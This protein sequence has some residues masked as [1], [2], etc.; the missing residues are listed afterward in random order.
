MNKILNFNIGNQLF[1]IEEDAY[2]GLNNYLKTLKTYFKYDKDSNEIMQ[3]LENR[4]AEIFTESISKKKPFVTQQDVENMMVKLGRTEDFDPV[5][6]GKITDKSGSVASKALTTSRKILKKKLMR[7]PNDRIIGGVCAGLGHYF[8]ISS[9]IIRLILLA[10]FLGAGVGFFLYIILWMIMPLAK[11]PSDFML[12]RGLP[13]DDS[14]VIGN[15][16]AKA[17]PL[18]PTY[19]N[20]ETGEKKLL[21][22]PNEKVI[23]GVSSGLAEYFYIDKVLVRLLFIGLTIFNGV[24]VLL[25][26]ILWIVMPNMFQTKALPSY[27]IN[28]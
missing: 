23:A 8:G 14:S 7:D 10:L 22:N 4:M 12:M 16:K 9:T 19:I 25:Y 3:D 6:K 24:G 21:R 17:E 15:I 27:S 26:I 5:V 28:Q 11:S 1:N 18:N 2:K 20:P 13:I